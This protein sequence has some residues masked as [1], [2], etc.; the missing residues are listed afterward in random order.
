MLYWG[1]KYLL[2][3]GSHQLAGDDIP[4]GISKS[5]ARWNRLAGLAPHATRSSCLQSV[6]RVIRPE[7]HTLSS[8]RLAKVQSH[9]SHTIPHAE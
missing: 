6:A 3:S 2:E 9:K 4:A 8:P 7:C 1:V 5:S